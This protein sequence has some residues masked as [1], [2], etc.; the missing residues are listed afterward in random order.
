MEGG[1]ENTGNIEER[2]ILPGKHTP[3]THMHPV[4]CWVQT[5]APE[6]EGLYQ[7]TQKGKSQC[8]GILLD[9]IRDS[10]CSI[11]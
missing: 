11:A 10:D 6:S 5:V 7:H 9:A 2:I 1:A 4:V 3:H 8:I